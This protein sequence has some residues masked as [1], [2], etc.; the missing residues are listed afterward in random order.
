MPRKIFTLILVFAG[1]YM[2]G[3]YWIRWRNRVA[4][5]TT[6]TNRLVECDPNQVTRIRITQGTENLSFNRVD[7]KQEGMPANAQLAR[8]EWRFS[9]EEGKEADAPALARVASMFCQIY[10]PVPM[11][12]ANAAPAAGSGRADSIFIETS[13]KGEA[14]QY[15]LRYLTETQDKMI[16]VEYQ[17]KAYKI[18][19]ELFLAAS[20]PPGAFVNYRVARMTPDS[21]QAASFI[22]DGRERFTLEREGSDWRVLSAGKV[23]G[24]GSDE[25]GR[26]VNRISTLLALEVKDAQ[27]S[28]EQC[29][30]GAHK[31]RVELTGLANRRETIYFDNKA[32][33]KGRLSACSTARPSLFMVHAD[34]MK[35]FNQPVKKLMAVN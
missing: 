23:M 8:S 33:A 30:K 35:Y 20:L 27:I 3:H 28:A 12:S 7:N 1:F 19:K 29:E 5:D 9:G 25:A 15:E 32:P 17:G 26:F 22:I 10:D 13:E 31:V 16:L 34:L 4:D 18:M 14:R 21:I 24:K 6:K 11:R 2:A